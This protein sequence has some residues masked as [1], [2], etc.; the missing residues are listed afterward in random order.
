MEP[1]RARRASQALLTIVAA[2]VLA[3]AAA[4]AAEG[5][6]TPPRD[7]V[8]GSGATAFSNDFG[9][10][11][12][13]GP[14]G[15]DPTG[16]FGYTVSISYPH[17]LLGHVASQSPTCLA[18]HGNTATAVGPVAL[19]DP[20]YLDPGYG[21]KVT[22]VDNGQTGSGPDTVGI[23]PVYGTLSPSD[24]DTPT[25]GDPLTRGD[26]VVTDSQPLPTAM[27]QCRHGGWRDY[28]DRF[29][30][31]GHCMAFVLRRAVHACQAER[32]ALGPAAFREKYGVL[33]VLRCVKLAVG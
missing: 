29:R 16:G 33:G 22:V 4:Q 11:M 14:S 12:S 19:V 9:I 24:C 7:S 1:H 3:P 21:I 5:P 15:E 2:L 26:I 8:T 13:S 28:G 27:A 31:Q 20:F 30:N 25:G 17:L 10:N 6:A 23:T 32:E 18:V